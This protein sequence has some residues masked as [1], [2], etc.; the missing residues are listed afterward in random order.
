MFADSGIS[1]TVSVNAEHYLLLV[2]T[3]VFAHLFL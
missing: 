2:Q 3:R 1:L